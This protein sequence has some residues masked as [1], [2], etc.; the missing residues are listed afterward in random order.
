MDT[1]IQ[2]GGF[3]RAARALVN[4][5]RSPETRRAYHTALSAWLL[6]CVARGVRPEVATIQNA[7]E[8]RNGLVSSRQSGGVRL[9]LAALS[10]VYGDVFRAGGARGNPFHPVVLAWPSKGDR[11]QTPA[12]NQA[13]VEGVLRACVSDTDRLRGCRDAAL[14]SLCYSVG[15]RRA[16]AAGLRLEDVSQEGEK[17]VVDVLGKGGKRRKIGLPAEATTHLQRW[18]GSRKPPG[19]VFPARGGDA[20]HPATVNRILEARSLEVGVSRIAP[21]TL[22]AAFATDAYEASVQER[23][24][25]QAMGH[26][27]PSTTRLYDSG[28]RGDRA[29]VAV[30]ELR[31]SRT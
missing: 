15:L 29:V 14:V 2:V 22:R 8:Y 26:S 18:I 27:D 12:A 7:T 25:Q 28:K 3:E 21:H 20:M 31:R 11:R 6:F 16:E 24:T 23:D 19:A 4:A 5:K 30:A 13:T 10:S 1:I 17:T 9:T